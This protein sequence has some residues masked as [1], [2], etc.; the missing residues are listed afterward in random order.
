MCASANVRQ[1]ASLV[2]CQFLTGQHVSNEQNYYANYVEQK[3][4]E[5]SKKW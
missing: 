4:Q 3:Q 1:S 2:V 5:E